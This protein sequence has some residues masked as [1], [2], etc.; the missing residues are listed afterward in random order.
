MDFTHSIPI[1]YRGKN[2][3]HNKKFVNVL[4]Y[5]SK[6]VLFVIATTIVHKRFNKI[7]RVVEY[8][9]CN[10]RKRIDE[11]CKVSQK[12]GKKALGEKKYARLKRI[13]MQSNMLGMC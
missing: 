10:K 9:L 6:I 11:L 1:S 5:E 2:I 8:S 12:N 3:I 7:V 13:V 4:P